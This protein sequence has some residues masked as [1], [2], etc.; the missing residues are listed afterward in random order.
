MKPYR[1]G[2]GPPVTIPIPPSKSLTH[3]ALVAAAL[4]DGRSRIIDPLLCEDTMHT[5][6]G[7]RT[8]G[9]P[10]DLREGEII[11]QGTGGR[12]SARSERSTL[13]LGNSGTSFRFL[14]AVSALGSGQHLLTGARR[15][16]ERPIGGLCLGLEGLGARISFPATS[17]F[18][19]VLVRSRGL[20]GGKIRMAGDR[21]SQFVSALLLAAPCASGNVEINVTG[22]LVSRHYV[23]LTVELMG[24]FGVEVL[25]EGYRYFRVSAPRPYRAGDFRIEGD[26]SSASYFWA[27]AAVSGGS[28]TT[29]NIDPRLT[30]Q[31]DIGFLGILEEMGCSVERGT[32][33]V[34]V[35][36]GRLRAV[37]ADMS[38][39]PDMVPTLAAVALFAEGKTVIRNVPHL[40]LKESDRLRAV[41][42][43]WKRLGGEV[44]ESR[45]GLAIAG[46]R[47]LRPAETSAHDDHRIAMS[48]A[49]VGLMLP[50]LR[51][52]GARCVDKSYPGFWDAWHAFRTGS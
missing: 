30:H 23:D 13:F 17:G 35:R 25:Q 40:R 36:G 9:V 1:S 14:L 4:A 32:D 41:A 18:P 21:S 43:E 5:V 10:V 12:F 3:R 45:D 37:E 26:A 27:G 11:V 15:M 8:L 48:L 22:D 2:G 6:N 7:L 49:V 38:A 24:R 33:R 31:G 42:M 34:T 20:S 29:T 47:P 44:E 28:V 39:M 19:P 51:I 52:A 16:L 46:K 50:G